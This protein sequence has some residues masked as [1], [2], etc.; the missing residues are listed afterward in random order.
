MREIG[1]QFEVRVQP[2]GLR[3]R[4]RE[5]LV[6]LEAEDEAHEVRDGEQLLI[7]IAGSVSRTEVSLFGQEWAWTESVLPMFEIEGRP[8]RAFL[9]WTARERGLALRFADDALAETAATT[10]LSGS[11][12]GLTLKDALDVVLPTCQMAHRIEPGELVIEAVPP[13]LE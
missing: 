1:T 8:A 9:E 4:V 10:I 12:E 2:S 11:V 6:I 5:G 7:D 13:G 3:V